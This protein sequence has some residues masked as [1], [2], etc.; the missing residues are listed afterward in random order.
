MAKLKKNKIKEMS[1]DE[2][3]KKLEE[4]KSEL[5]YQR[6]LLATGNTTDSPGK[7][8]SLKKTIARLKTFINLDLREE[9]YM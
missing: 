4:Y 1:L 6:S 9:Q 7:I 5:A 3:M 2:K 8:G